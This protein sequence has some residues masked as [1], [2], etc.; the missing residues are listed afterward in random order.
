[1]SK[2]TANR[3]GLMWDG[4][5]MIM[6]VV[7]YVSFIE[8]FLQIVLGAPL[9]INMRCAIRKTLEIENSETAAC[10]SEEIP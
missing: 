9:S 6:P 5:V 2:V 10:N 7:L 3:N 1:M 4:S 8:F